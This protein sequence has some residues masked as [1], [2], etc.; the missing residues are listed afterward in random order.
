MITIQDKLHCV[1]RELGYR[2]RVYDRLVDNGKMTPQQRAR[3]LELMEA[4]V[5]D[6]RVLAEAEA[7]PLFS[8]GIDQGC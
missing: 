2:S 4:I 1:V 6:Y 8:D 3:E 5:E 7:L